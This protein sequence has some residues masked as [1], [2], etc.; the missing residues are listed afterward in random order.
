MAITATQ[1]TN[2][3]LD[4]GLL[5]DQTVFT[6]AEISAIWER[7]SDARTTELQHEASL[8]LMF[9]QLLNS[10]AKLHKVAVAGDSN[11]LQQVFDHYLKLYNMYKPALDGVLGSSQQVAIAT[12]RPVPRQ[13]R[14]TPTTSKGRE[15]PWQE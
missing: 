3:R 8:G 4:A 6:D 11:D 15:L 1:T 7:V 2:L 9:R 5:D 14:E 10:S 12:L 13:N